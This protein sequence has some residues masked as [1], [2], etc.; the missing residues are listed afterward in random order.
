MNFKNDMTEYI[1]SCLGII[2]LCWLTFRWLEVFPHKHR[3]QPHSTVVSS[4]LK[5]IIKYLMYLHG[6]QP[7]P[8]DIFLCMIIFCLEG[9][10]I[11][12]R[13]F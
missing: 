11:V 3:P 6:I 4:C 1:L 12:V 7:D 8:K 13:H 2:L 5:E 9:V 10:T